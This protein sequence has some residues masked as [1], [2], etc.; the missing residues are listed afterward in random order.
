MRVGIYTHYAHCD[1]AYLALRLVEFCRL[2]GIDFDIYSDQPPARLNLPYDKIVA[3]R[4]VMRFTDWAQKQSAIVW[5]H[6][7]KIEQI[8]YA[9]RINKTTIL[10]P[11]WQELVP[12]FRKAMKRADTVVALSAECYE[13]YKDVYKLRNTSLIPFDVGLPVT[14]KDARVDQRHVKVF[15]PWFDRNARCANSDFLGA[16]AF[17][18]ERMPEIALTVAISSSKFSPAIAKFFHSLS[19]RTSGRVSVVRNIRLAERAHLF[20]THDLTLFPAECDNF[21][22]CLLTSISCG[23][24]VLSFAVSPQ[25]DFVYQDANGVLVKTKTDFD[26]NGVPH[27]IPNYDALLSALQNLVDEPWHI[28]NL[29]NRITYNLTARRKAFELGWAAALGFADP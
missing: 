19:A 17:L 26:E 9:N 16:L 14:R 3:H 1:Q 12:P 10:A 15:L 27:A 23:T 5:T 4:S 6:V 18:I 29:N 24:P 13:L 21:G 22:S 8:N 25:I 7:P 11:M 28:D 20:A 2:Y